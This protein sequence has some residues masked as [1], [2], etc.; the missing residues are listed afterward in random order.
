LFGLGDGPVALERPPVRLGRFE[1]LISRWKEVPAA[2]GSGLR[3]SQVGQFYPLLLV[4]FD[5]THPQQGRKDSSD[6]RLKGGLQLE[7]MKEER[8]VQSWEAKAALLVAGLVA[9]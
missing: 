6:G 3:V 1:E 4:S 7:G 9:N 2:T 8:K 5:W